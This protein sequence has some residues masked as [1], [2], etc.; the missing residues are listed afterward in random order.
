MRH[1]SVPL[2][3]GVTCLV[4]AIVTLAAVATTGLGIIQASDAQQGQPVVVSLKGVSFQPQNLSVPVGTTV[5]WRNDEP[6]KTIH[7]VTGGPLASPD[8]APGQSYSFTFNTAGTFT[9]HCRFH[10]YMEGQ[11][12]V[13]G[14]AATTTSAPSPVT[15]APPGTS[16]G[17]TGNGSQY[18]GEALGDGT[19]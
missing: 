6:D 8:L 3:T 18:V 1:H 5:T 19:F 10:G 11:I 7:S 12:T 14:S 16:P 15:T 17:G 4:T 2:R 9:Y 13:T